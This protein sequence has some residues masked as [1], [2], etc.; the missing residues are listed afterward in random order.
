MIIYNFRYTKEHLSPPRII[1]SASASVSDASG[2]RLNYSLGTIGAQILQQPPTSYDEYREGDVGL[3]PF[4]HDVPKIKGS[5]RK[6]R[7]TE[8][9]KVKPTDI[10]ENEQQ[11]VEILKFLFDWYRNDK[12]NPAKITTPLT[13]AGISEIN[14]ELAPVTVLKFQDDKAVETN[15]SLTD[16]FDRNSSHNNN[17]EKSHKRHNQS[18]I[19]NSD[20][21]FLQHEGDYVDDNYEPIVFGQNGEREEPVKTAT[22]HNE[23][24]KNLKIPEDYVDDNVEPLYYN[25]RNKNDTVTET[26]E[27]HSDSEEAKYKIIDIDKAIEKLETHHTPSDVLEST[28]E[29]D[30]ITESQTPSNSHL[31]QSNDNIHHNSVPHGDNNDNNTTVQNKKP[32]NDITHK[33]KKN[34]RR[35]RRKH[36]DPNKESNRDNIDFKAILI[37]KLIERPYR[38]KDDY[39]YLKTVSNVISSTVK[40]QNLEPIE[41]ESNKDIILPNNSEYNNSADMIHN[42]E[43][44]ELPT[45]AEPL[46]VPTL[47]LT[48]PASGI[49]A[50][51][52]KS[53]YRNSRR[54]KQRYNSGEDKVPH[55]F[56]I[57]NQH[58]RSTATAI[59]GNDVHN[60]ETDVA[61]NT[62]IVEHQSNIFD[63]IPLIGTAQ[64]TPSY[65]TSNLNNDMHIIVNLGET[66]TDDEHL[67]TSTTESSEKDTAVKE[68]DHIVQK[69]ATATENGSNFYVQSTETLHDFLENNNITA[70]SV[71]IIDNDVIAPKDVEDGLQYE[72]ESKIAPLEKNPLIDKNRTVSHSQTKIELYK[73]LSFEDENQT[74]TVSIISSDENTSE[75]QMNSRY[76]TVHETTTEAETIT[77]EHL[78]DPEN[79]ENNYIKTGSDNILYESTTLTNEV[80]SEEFQTID[81]RED[82]DKSVQSNNSLSEIIET[83]YSNAKPQHINT[84]SITYDFTT[85]INN[86]GNDYEI[87]NS[88][89]VLDINVKTNN[90]IDKISEPYDNYSNLRHQHTKTGSILY[91]STM[92]TNNPKKDEYQTINY[93]GDS[94][95]H[96]NSLLPLETTTPLYDVELYTSPQNDSSYL[97]SKHKNVDRFEKEDINNK[98]QKNIQYNYITSTTATTDFYRKSN[99]LIQVQSTLPIE[100]TETSYNQQDDILTETETT[101]EKMKIEERNNLPHY[102]ENI[103]ITT[104]FLLETGINKEGYTNL[105]DGVKE[106]YE[107][108]THEES[109]IKLETTTLNMEVSTDTE[110]P[111]TVELATTQMFPDTSLLPETTTTTTNVPDIRI[112]HRRKSRRKGIRP[113]RIQSSPY[114][115]YRHRFS[116]YQ[117]TNHPITSEN[118]R[119]ES[120]YHQ[121]EYYSDEVSTEAP[122]KNNTNHPV[123]SENSRY[124]I[125]Y[126]QQEYN[127]EE[128]STEAPL[129]KNA[130]PTKSEQA[131]D[132]SIP[133]TPL[134]KTTVKKH[135][136]FNCFNK[137]LDKFYPD[138][139]DCRLFHYCTQGYTK[140]QL[141]DLKF[142]CDLNT[143][144]DDKSLICTKEKP[145]RCL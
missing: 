65:G 133:T 69:F 71:D 101:T 110:V 43:S 145:T 44:I 134:S 122:L 79:P 128:L 104:S 91:G 81:Y 26:Q 132:K 77:Q 64:T 100:I 66:H 114:S 8:D 87:N 125:G 63:N 140:N 74:N 98:Q 121:Q 15:S 120:G 29:D 22:N 143:F 97:L 40:T 118:S 49:S 16:S 84:D 7:S 6:K 127:L 24:H 3:D 75:S 117:S 139:R 82:S 135:Y 108:H 47:P 72:T 95:L 31:N 18:E 123:T 19:S 102:Y 85:S 103:E 9:K 12:T 60:K 105:Q 52:A 73:H 35:G 42:S 11:A 142:V 137:G 10:I 25:E 94:D 90:S 89:N 138:P 111:T 115:R 93:G 59:S 51:T 58:S 86:L 88:K 55:R 113:S 61:H 124:K 62:H 36:I 54:G 107:S 48:V 23:K 126:H 57:R 131:Q 14:T 141:L 78:Q 144:F 39:D 53:N 67:I 5:T 34:R 109:T 112:T 30:Y 27:K 70:I 2:R 45:S 80:G 68:K 17:D 106:E 41:N 119:Y 21:M 136:F 33:L 32:L 13:S 99:E 38:A 130:I 83:N 56:R 76:S 129:K 20:N 46:T 50:S 92:L 37:E 4:Y 116:T 1:I 96:V 28:N